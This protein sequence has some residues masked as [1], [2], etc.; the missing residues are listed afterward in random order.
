MAA[1]ADAYDLAEMRGLLDHARRTAA[2]L[3]DRIREG[4]ID[5]APAQL[6]Q[7]SACD[8]CDYAAICRRD[9]ALPGG[10]KR[11]LTPLTRQELAQRIANKDKE[12]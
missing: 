10:E 9:P 12:E 5:I 3:A 2:D 1:T 4:R 11:C 8:T 6:A 7:W